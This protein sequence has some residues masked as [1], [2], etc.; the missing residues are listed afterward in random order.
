VLHRPLR[1]PLAVVSLLSL[2]DY[3]LWNWSLSGSHGVLALI[4]GLALT[5]L[6][7]ALLWLL[8]L[9]AARLLAAA[10]RRTRAPL[11]AHAGIR[12][13]G[14]PSRQAARAARAGELAGE[15]QT[16]AGTRAAHGQRAPTGAGVGETP[17]PASPTSKLAA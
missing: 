9:G 15:L 4:A 11:D 2:G 10:S 5:P 8:V 14:T 13:G 12:R 6:L 17:S 16:T 7:I 3:L 1:W